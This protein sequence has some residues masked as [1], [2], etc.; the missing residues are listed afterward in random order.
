MRKPAR[1]L[2]SIIV[3]FLVSL[4][5]ATPNL[6]APTQDVNFLGTAI[7]ATMASGATQTGAAVVPPSA[8]VVS[9]T[10]WPTFTPVPPLATFTPS[11]SPSAT[12]S[13]TATATSTS[14]TPSISVSVPTNCRTGPG[15][16][17]DRVGA[18]LVGE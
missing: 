17:Y 9:P 11:A 16:V 8:T 5:C 13:P 12:S 6:P 18:R 3:L 7:M 10:P 1:V 15:K 14:L 4:A 2:S